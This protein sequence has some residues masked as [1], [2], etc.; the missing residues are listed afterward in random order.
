MTFTSNA[1]SKKP[2]DLLDR[3]LEGE[4]REATAEIQQLET[5]AHELR[6]Q[7]DNIAPSPALMN[8]I[9]SSLVVSQTE[10][11]KPIAAPW[12]TTLRQSFLVPLGVLSL[13]IVAGV[14]WTLLNNTITPGPLADAGTGLETTVADAQLGSEESELDAFALDLEEDASIELALAEI[15]LLLQEMASTE[16]TSPQESSSKNMRLDPAEFDA[17]Q[18]AIESDNG[19]ETYFKEEEQFQSFDNNLATT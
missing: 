7:K 9:L 18:T 17:E 14:S 5:L 13:L 19:F 4:D 12:Y 2:E 8:T 1:Q 3:L 10:E 15:D 11:Q 6:A 16:T